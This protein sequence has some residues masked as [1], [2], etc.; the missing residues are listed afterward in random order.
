MDNEL[1]MVYLKLNEEDL[2]FYYEII[3]S[4][5]ENWKSSNLLNKANQ[6]KTK[7]KF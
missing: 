4:A 7:Q 2:P 6:S 1:N 5:R 3:F